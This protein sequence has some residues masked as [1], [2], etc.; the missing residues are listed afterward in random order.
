MNDPTVKFSHGDSVISAYDS[1]LDLEV[2]GSYAA[3]LSIKGSDLDLRV[4]DFYSYRYI[5]LEKI[6][7]N[8]TY[9]SLSWGNSFGGK[10]RIR[11]IEVLKRTRM[12]II[13]CQDTKTDIEFDISTGTSAVNRRHIE[14]CRKA[15]KHWT[16][17]HHLM[18][19]LKYYLKVRDCDK[20][21]T[22]GISS[23]LLF[24]LIV[25]FYQNRHARIAKYLNRPE[26]IQFFKF[27]ARF[28]EQKDGICIDLS[29]LYPDQY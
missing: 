4:N 20:S 27:Y 3:R 16:G 5:D 24:Y 25:G 17:L 21:F 29:E 22:G 13:K 28:N 6:S 15:Q 8:L 11:I 12:P 1:G 19:A 14:I 26:L 23:F 10:D 18:L 9:N 7:N 2:F